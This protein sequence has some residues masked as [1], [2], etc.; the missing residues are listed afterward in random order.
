M[1]FEKLLTYKYVPYLLIFAAALSVYVLIYTYTPGF[2]PSANNWHNNYSR[3]AY[4]WLQGRLDLPENRHYL[5][6]AFFNDRFY[7]SFPPF[8]SIVLLP[9]VIMYG[10]N[11]PDH[12]IA[13]A[14]AFIS[15]F[16][17]Y[18]IAESQLRNK[19]HAMFFSL[20]LILGTNYLHIS[21]WGAVWYLAQNMAFAFTLMSF[22]F[23]L[24]GNERHSF[25]SLAAFCAAMGCRPFSAIYLPLLL[26]LLYRRGGQ[27]WAPFVKKLLI[28]AMPAIALGSFFMWLNYARFG[29]VFEFGHNFLP[30][31]II[32]YRG[33]F[34]PR[35]IPQNIRMLFFDLGISHGALHG[36]PHYGRTSFAFWVASP[37]VISYAV[38]LFVRCHAKPEGEKDICLWL[39]PLLVFLHLFAFSFHRTLGA[40]QFGSRYSVDTLPAVY[41]GLL[42]ILGKLPAKNSVYM[43]IAPMIFGKLINFH[44]TIAFLT[45]YFG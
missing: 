39:I 37:I 6:I 33:Q 19:K 15:L 29:N 24:T 42:F 10:Y 34:H 31:H 27:P 18:K 36:F 2:S 13:L 28:W 43:N 45:F 9:F 12:A 30:E 22:Y 35:R 41:L 40:R 3:Q 38:Y 26:Y 20:F 14:F 23:A 11:T 25:I 4:S 21:L 1:D 32:D 44:G 17:A 5:E 7:I 8:P 16:F